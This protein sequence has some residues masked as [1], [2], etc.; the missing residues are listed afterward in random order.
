MSRTLNKKLTK[1][2]REVVDYLVSCMEQTGFM[3]STREIQD[4][5]NFSSQTAAVSHLRALERKGAIERSPNKARALRVIEGSAESPSTLLIPVYGSIVAGMAEHTEQSSLDDDDCI[6]VDVRTLGIPKGAKTFALRVRG[7]SMIDAHIC[8]GDVVIMEFREPRYGD[9][10]AALIDG[11]TT[12]KRYIV[13]KDR[14]FLRAENDNFPD[15]I[16]VEELI[17]Q[18]VMVGLL[19]KAS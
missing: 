19:R 4:H 3:P 5:F 14:A 18:G 10:V 11:E 16:P 2:Q 13:V 1:R 12:L 15:M 7:D 6:A 9:V 8:P 17:V